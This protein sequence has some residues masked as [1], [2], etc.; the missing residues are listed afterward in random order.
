MNPSSGLPAFT[1]HRLVM[2]VI[3]GGAILGGFAILPGAN[4][5][6]AMLERDGHSREALAI[7][8]SEYAHGDRRYRTLYQMQAL[9]ESEGN[10]AKARELL[11]AMV[12]ANPRDVSVRG[13][14]AQFYKNI[15]EQPLY[16]EAL[17]KQID[18]KYSESACRELVAIERMTG[19]FQ[20][21]QR[22]LQQCRQR[23]Y[24]RPD[25]LSR[26]AELVAADSDGAQAATIL[27]SIDDLKRLKTV[28]ERY[29]LLTLLL[30]QDQPKEAE[31]R[32]VR[33]IRGSKDDGLAIGLVDT[34]ARS[35]FPNS[36]MEVAKDVG[37]PGDSISLTVAERLIE[38]SEMTA[39]QLYLKGWLDKAPLLQETV[40]IRFVEAALA[41]GDSATALKGARKFSLEKL[42]APLLARLAV[43]LNNTGLQADAA[44]VQRA[45][46]IPAAIPSL[47]AP[48]GSGAAVTGPEGPVTEI[49]PGSPGSTQVALATQDP[50]EPW[51]RTLWSKLSVDAVRRGQALGISPPPVTLTS[52][53][54]GVRNSGQTEA[55]PEARS[56]RHSAGSTKLLKK[57]NRVLQRTKR[58]KSLGHRRKSVRDSVKPVPYST[59]PVPAPNPAPSPVP[60]PPS[61][62]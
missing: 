28:R 43:D 56:E 20:A 29:Q 9:Y 23:G 16:V 44:E 32:A 2:A 52:E 50:L 45:A 61:R 30:E 49:V 60:K 34:L 38:R 3:F 35:K 22:S 10:V 19:D 36:A 51:R 6:V 55:R 13:R 31:R 17:K 46:G 40:A 42:N 11:E 57:T 25:D 39:A 5:R 54:I 37:A 59:L 33:W 21:E 48:E 27:R 15:Q 14:L 8:E 4:E 24:R 7:L 47:L 53:P 62:Q 58:L 41:A 12:A 26:L 18:L 1:P